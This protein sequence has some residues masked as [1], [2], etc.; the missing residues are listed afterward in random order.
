M[1]GIACAE[2]TNN[3]SVSYDPPYLHVV[4]TLIPFFQIK[5]TVGACMTA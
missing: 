2:I 1:K 4:Y 5:P 3:M